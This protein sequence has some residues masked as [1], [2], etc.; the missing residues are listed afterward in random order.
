M[1]RVRSSLGPVIVLVF[2]ALSL[3]P[4]CGGSVQPADGPTLAE[5]RIFPAELVQTP[6]VLPDNKANISF[7]PTPGQNSG[8]TTPEPLAASPTAVSSTEASPSI[9][10]TLVPPPTPTSAPAITPTPT[11][12]PT[13]TAQPT[14]SLLPPAT[15]VPTPAPTLEPT[16][17]PSPTPPPTPTL[18]PAQVTVNGT[19]AAV[20]FPAS[21]VFSLEALSAIPLEKI[22]LEFGTEEVFSCSSSY[23]T[24]NQE[25]ASGTNVKTQWTWEFKKSG[26]PPPG[27]L[28]WW[29]WRIT[30]D[31]GRRTVTPQSE[32]LYEDLRFD[33]QTINRDNIT[34]H[35]YDGGPDFGTRILNG[36]DKGLSRLQLGSQLE[37]PINAFVYS[38][39]EDVQGSALFVRAWVGGRA[40]TNYNIVLIAISP[41]R[42]DSQISGLTHELAHLL[43][44][45]A[46]FNCLGGLPSWLSE[47]LAMY[48]QGPLDEYYQ[49]ALQDATAN[50]GLISVRSL[51]SSFPT[52]HGGANLSY[53]QSHSLVNYLLTYYDWEK[54]RELLAVFKTGSTPD[55][56]LQAVY[57]FDRDGL[58][59]RWRRYIGAK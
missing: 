23:S 58:D 9:P 6:T 47:G 42:L 19:D 27:A 21:I 56:A 44:G 59:S 46:T 51:S 29:R 45:E 17:A 10:P 33:W 54:M 39:S 38:S 22:A 41:G 7:S 1:T 8:G 37:K 32:L 15:A 24:V 34:I 43:V 13:A 35:W 50:D 12:V 18:G 16:L 30:D 55:K 52:G 48:S 2:L 49:T 31:A 57:G 4:G 20:N 25:F 14:P 36:V 40:Y 53:A 11:P 28:V 3:A 5:T 26:S